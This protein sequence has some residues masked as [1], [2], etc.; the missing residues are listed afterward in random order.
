MGAKVN[1]RYLTYARY[2][3][4]EALFEFKT[5]DANGLAVAVE[6]NDFHS[7]LYHTFMGDVSGEDCWN[8]T[9]STIGWELKPITRTAAGVPESITPPF[10]LP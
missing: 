9:D 3:A 6:A 10:T 7:Y 8:T 5:L 2:G 1:G 4:T